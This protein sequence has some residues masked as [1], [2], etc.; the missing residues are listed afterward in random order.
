ML[1]LYGIAVRLRIANQVQ[2]RNQRGFFLVLFIYVHE[3][4]V[5][6]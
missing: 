5:C 2:K 4:F 1:V 3:C 6:P